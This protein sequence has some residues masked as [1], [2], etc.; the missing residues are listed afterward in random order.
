M[1]ENS[2][3]QCSGCNSP[4]FPNTLDNGSLFISVPIA[5]QIQYILQTPELQSKLSYRVDR[6]SKAENIISDIYDSDLYKVL[7]AP[8]EILL[9]PNNLSYTFNSDGSPLYKSSKY[10]IWPIHLHLNELPPNTQFKHVM[11]AGL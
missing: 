7:S 1:L 6:P 5:P 4:V 3:T 2:V 9:D 10:S 8:G 11:S